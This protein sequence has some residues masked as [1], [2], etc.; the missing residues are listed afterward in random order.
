M[1][2]HRV[3]TVIIERQ[4]HECGW[5]DTHKTVRRLAMLIVK[6]LHSFILGRWRIARSGLDFVGKN[7]IK[8]QKKK[9][10]AERIRMSTANSII[11]C[12]CCLTTCFDLQIAWT[13]LRNKWYTFKGRKKL[14]NGFSEVRKW[15][16]NLLMMLRKCR[17]Y[18]TWFA[19][20]L[21]KCN[22]TAYNIWNNLRQHT[23]AFETC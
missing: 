20:W 7:E 14:K 9:L 11:M 8:G 23:N 1:Q 5:L 18:W 3:E 6:V 22:Y 19:K 13:T 10:W 17:R 4:Y 12:F 16:C 15:L 21:C 2:L